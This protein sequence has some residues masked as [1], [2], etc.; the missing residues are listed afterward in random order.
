LSIL[1]GRLQQEPSTKSIF[2]FYP[3]F[4][5]LIFHLAPEAANK[6]LVFKGYKPNFVGCYFSLYIG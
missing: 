2:E 6:L 3:T 4:P 1:I 5:W